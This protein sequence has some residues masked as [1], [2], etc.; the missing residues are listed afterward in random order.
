MKSTI[1]LLSAS[2]FVVVAVMT[3][4]GPLIPLIA[5]EFGETV[6]SVGIIVTAYAVP[7]GLF[8]IVF[9]PI[10][11]RVGKLRVIAVTLAIS[12]VFT[13]ACGLVDSLGGLTLF[14]FLSGLSSAAA[15][16]L[17][18][19]YIADEVPY[20]I[21]QPVI[22][23]YVSGIIL[24]HV[25]GASFGGIAAE[26][27][28]WRHVFLFLAFVSAAISA[29]LL[30]AAVQRPPAVRSAAMAP[31]QIFATWRGLFATR[32]TRDVILVA[33][34]EGVLMFGVLA[35]F[36]AFLRHEH[37]LSYALI[38]LVLAAYGVGGVTYS[39]LVHRIVRL[40]GERGMIVG[41]ALL[42]GGCYVALTLVPVWWMSAPVLVV[43]GLGFYMFHNTM[44]TQATELSAEARG[45]AMSLWVF[46]LFAGQGLG[47]TVFGAVIDGPGYGTALVTAGVGVM[48]L[49]LW[50]SRRLRTLQG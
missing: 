2:S 36:G 6:G 44:Q 11:D 39:L 3:V 41:G 9:G 35:F 50:F 24:G 31:A 33:L 4:T 43:A 29:A 32:R 42:L 47:V 37:A 12:T 21:R 46:M 10:G 45:T 34:L 15:V 22:G 28:D 14:R 27:F 13:A 8:Q 16:P 26:Y 38:G 23:R 48:L 49:G 20:E 19:A 18:M 7:Y 1:F 17:A 40:F 5:E 25:A 30:A